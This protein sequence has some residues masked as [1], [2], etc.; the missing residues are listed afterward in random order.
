A[1]D[2]EEERRLADAWFEKSAGLGLK[3]ISDAA[4]AI[5]AG[6]WDG[7]EQVLI[8]TINPTYRV[9]AAASTQLSDFLSQRGKANGLAVEDRI[10]NTSYL[11]T[12]AVV[13]SLLLAVGTTM[14]LIRG[15][16]T[17]L[18]QAIGIARRVAGG[19]LG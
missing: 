17:P 14:M 18:N 2:S 15:I 8:S 3:A 11:L 6:K 7:A 16:T 1:I 19:D 9:G 4:V 10:T 13:L 5:K 12:G